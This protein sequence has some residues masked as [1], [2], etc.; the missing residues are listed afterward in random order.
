MGL[1]MNGLF[2]AH[3][4]Q[5]LAQD[6][7]PVRE[8]FLQLAPYEVFSDKPPDQR[9]EPAKFKGINDFRRSVLQ[10]LK[11]MAMFPIAER[12]IHQAVGKTPL[13]LILHDL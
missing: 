5:L 12:P 3:D 6:L 2:I 4:F 1:A 9:M 11:F 13:R 7:F 8:D 10:R